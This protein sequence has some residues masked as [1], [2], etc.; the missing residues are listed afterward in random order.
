MVD[1]ATGEDADVAAEQ[2]RDKHVQ[3][4][5]VRLTVTTEDLERS[6]VMV[7]DMLCYLC[8]TL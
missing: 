8:Y 6:G 3:H 5:L 7:K 1:P 4:L 2:W